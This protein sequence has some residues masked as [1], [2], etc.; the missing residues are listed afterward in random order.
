MNK[1]IIYILIPIVIY[2]GYIAI[3]YAFCI[4]EYAPITESKWGLCYI[5]FVGLGVLTVKLITDDIIEK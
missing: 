1:Y 5:A 3:R 2:T 4:P